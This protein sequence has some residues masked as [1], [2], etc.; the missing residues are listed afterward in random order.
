[1]EDEHDAADALRLALKLDRHTVEVAYNGPEGVAK[2]CA[3]RP[4]VVLCDIGLPG[5][6][7]FE[8]ARMLRADPDF[9]GTL[10]V[11]LTGYAQPEDVERTRQAGFDRHL[12][13]P[14]D[15]GALAVVLAKAPRRSARN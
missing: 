14:P 5:M 8:V 1:I 15:L 7:G 11:A 9:A 4:D 3:F 10:L 2:A 6:D 12:A 13:K